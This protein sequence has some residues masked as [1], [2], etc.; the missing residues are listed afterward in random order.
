[1]LIIVV[2]LN[3]NNTPLIIAMKLKLLFFILL[4]CAI[5]KAQNDSGL[6]DF[7]TKNHS[8]IRAVQKNMSNKKNND[9]NNQFKEIIK[10]QIASVKLYNVNKEA[11]ACFALSVRN[12]CVN[13]L[14]SHTEI[15]TSY[16]EISKSEEITNKTN[17]YKNT[18]FLS[19]NE[20]KS[21]EDLD[22]INLQSLNTL[23][24]TVK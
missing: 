18:M 10:N 13:F 20:I 15:S 14:K 19:Q 16:F 6:K 8:V 1:M 22:V 2:F 21:I 4:F 24:L 5:I 9:F 11:S 17:S 3:L 23:I 7:I 12:E